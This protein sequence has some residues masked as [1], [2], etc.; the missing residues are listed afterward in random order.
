MPFEVGKSGNPQGRPKG[1]KGNIPQTVKGAIS[2][3]LESR[4]DQIAAKLDAV[5]DPVKWLE[6][7][8][9]FAVFIIPKNVKVET[10]LS[11]Y[12][13]MSNEELE[14]E[15]QKIHTEA[16]MKLVPIDD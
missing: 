10:E 14:A 11:P 1:A 9:K 12:E 15:I 4:A 2:E 7:Y 3:A 5:T 13:G 16:G 8:A 6:L